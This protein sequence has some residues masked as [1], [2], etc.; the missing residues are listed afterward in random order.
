MKQEVASYIVATIGQL[1]TT[2][3]SHEIKCSTVHGYQGLCQLKVSTSEMR[4]L[5][6]CPSFLLS[7]LQPIADTWGC[8]FWVESNRDTGELTAYIS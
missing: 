2:Y 7:K 3:P 6:F 8:I 1:A 5:G 4:D